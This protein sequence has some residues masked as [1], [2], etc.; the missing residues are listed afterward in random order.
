[1]TRARGVVAALVGLLLAPGLVA[2]CTDDP[3]ARDDHVTDLLAVL[4]NDPDAARAFL[5]GDEAGPEVEAAADEADAPDGH[6]VAW[7]LADIDLDA[8]RTRVVLVVLRGATAHDDAAE[9]AQVGTI[10]TQALGTPGIDA[11]LRGGLGQ[12]FADDTDLVY[13]ALAAAAADPV[14]W[15]ESPQRTVLRD[16]GTV[17]SVYEATVAGL[18]REVR[19]R[20][21][22]I[23]ADEET[24]RAGEEVGDP[25]ARLVGALTAGAAGATESGSGDVFAAGHQ[26]VHR[27]MATWA[28]A[29][30]ADRE[31][32]IAL[33]NRVADEVIREAR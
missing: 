22:A 13:D 3:P 1:M 8:D 10:L 9:A 5:A 17:P 26:R 19:A 7:L 27:L 31:E 4:V 2:G 29:R 16:L 23:G 33:A 20:L 32:R 28:V 18:E 21:G 14:A 24:L 30:R 25:F 6:R 12:A 11:G 15:A